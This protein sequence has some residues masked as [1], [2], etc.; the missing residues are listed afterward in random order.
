MVKLKPIGYCAGVYEYWELDTRLVR[1]GDGKG[2]LSK[3]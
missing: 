3:S 1:Y 2:L